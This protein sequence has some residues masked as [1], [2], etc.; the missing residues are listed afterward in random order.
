MKLYKLSLALFLGLGLMAS[1]SDNLNVE[2]PNDQTSGTFGFNANDLEESVIAAYNHTRMGGSYGRVSYTF[3]VTRGDEVWNS[4]QQ[5]YLP[6]DDYDDPITDD[7]G[8]GP[9][10]DWY[11]T[12]N[13]CNFGLSRCGDDDNSLSQQMK[14][15]KGQLL[16][17][18]GLA[19]YNLVGYYQNPPLITDYSSYSTLEGLYGSNSSYD[20]IWDQIEKD[21]SEAM[22]LLPSRDED[23]EPILSDGRERNPPFSWEKGPAPF[24]LS[25]EH[26]ATRLMPARVVNLQ[27]PKGRRQDDG[28]TGRC[29]RR[30]MGHRRCGIDGRKRRHR[31]TRKRFSQ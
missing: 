25:L 21:F 5:W 9:Y 18:R 11:Y 2:N 23:P 26:R 28:K 20:E 16:F 24:G 8:K 3:D 19:Y 10:M 17:L 22:T 15:I 29:S 27:R 4:S 7:I 1:C 12:V 6:F 31:R 13:V 30:G 14:R